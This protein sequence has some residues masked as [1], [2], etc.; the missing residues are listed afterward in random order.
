ME[1]E[2]GA[3]FRRQPPEAAFELISIRNALNGVRAGRSVDRQDANVRGPLPTP[4]RFRIAGV[5][6]ESREPGIE[7][8]RIAEAGQL[9]PGDHQ[10]LLHRILGPV[11][12]AEDPLGD[13][14][15]PVSAGLRQAA[16][17]LPVAPLGQLDEIAIHRCLG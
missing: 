12:I 3:L 6:E 14:E 13:R 2:Q 5:D 15:E 17:G 1:D 4:A 7:P 10:S 11:D 16:K 9:T 8:V